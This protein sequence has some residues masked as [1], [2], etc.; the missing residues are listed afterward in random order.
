[1]IIFIAIHKY[2]MYC[3]RL[4]H[5]TL[6][7]FPPHRSSLTASGRRR[8]QRPRTF[9]CFHTSSHKICQ[10]P[11]QYPPCP[12]LTSTPTGGTRC[13]SL[14][15]NEDSLV[16]SLLLHPVSG[17][18]RYL[19]EKTCRLVMRQIIEPYS[20]CLCYLLDFSCSHNFK[21]IQYTIS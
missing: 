20:R 4:C 6:R 10:Q 11:R 15:L 19:D 12:T 2:K 21:F 16:L 1:M 5:T 8:S 9:R 13:L 18:S 14:D 3:L 17:S 7:R